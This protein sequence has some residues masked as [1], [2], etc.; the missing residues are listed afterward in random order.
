MS[1]RARMPVSVGEKARQTD[2]LLRRLGGS[3]TCSPLEKARWRG[4]CRAPGGTKRQGTAGGDDTRT[5]GVVAEV[6][7]AGD[8]VSGR[9]GG[10]LGAAGGELGTPP[11][12]RAQK[13][14]PARR[15]GRVQRPAGARQSVCL[16]A[17]RQAGGPRCGRC[18]AML[19]ERDFPS[20]RSARSRRGAVKEDPKCP[21][22]QTQGMRHC[23]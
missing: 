13:L 12:S 7:W 5:Y 15:G 8:P 4:K 2:V 11:G 21:K 20:Q 19:Q 16:L 18:K 10:C 22:D 1:R 23:R 9:T 6:H 14:R 3:L 17:G